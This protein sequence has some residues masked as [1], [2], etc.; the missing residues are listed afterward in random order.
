MGFPGLSFLLGLC[1]AHEA[2][3]TRERM[4]R[5][6]FN[7]ANLSNWTIRHTKRGRGLQVARV[8]RRQVRFGQ[9]VKTCQTY[10]RHETCY[11]RLSSLS[12]H[13]NLKPD[14][15]SCSSPARGRSK[16][17]QGEAL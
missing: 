8:R 4:I 17:A 15:P 3:I 11:L 12:T 7:G 13:R 2:N 1:D 14:L 9:S 16:S 6:F 10:L 5:S